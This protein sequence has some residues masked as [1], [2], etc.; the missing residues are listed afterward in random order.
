MVR[1]LV[2]IGPRMYG[3][4]IA[5][6]LRNRRPQVEVDLAARETLDSEALR[7]K[8]ALVVCNEATPTVREL[9]RCWVAIRVGKWLDA[10]INADGYSSIVRDVQI[11][12]LVAAV[13]KVAEK[14]ASLPT[15]RERRV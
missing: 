13:D 6:S 4:T 5:F 14:E 1:V 11:G 8:P 7:L 9:A 15:R 10:E 2:A 3:E 12:D